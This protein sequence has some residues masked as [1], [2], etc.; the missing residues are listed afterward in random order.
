MQSAFS[1]KVG[2]YRILLEAG[3]RSE[4]LTLDTVYPVPYS[5]DWCAG[6]ANVR[7]DLCPVIDMHGVLFK[8]QRPTKQYL[9]WL[10]HEAFAPVVVSC[11]ELPKQITIPDEA[12]QSGR[13][14]GMPGWIQTVWS[15]DNALL[16]AADHARLFRLLSKTKPSGATATVKEK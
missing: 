4:V 8:Q 2:D 13:I 12:A 16:L 7:G 5:P 11:D 9:L 1:Y 10:Q 3:V 6:L 15:Q 14:P